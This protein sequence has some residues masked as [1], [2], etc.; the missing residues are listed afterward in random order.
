M[1]EA[2]G[3]GRRRSTIV[4]ATATGGVLAIA[5]AL[6]ATVITFATAPASLLPTVTPSPKDYV[7]PFE[8][9]LDRGPGDPFP[10]DLARFG[11]FVDASHGFL[12]VY[13][14]GRN[15]QGEPDSCRTVIMATNDG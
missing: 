3:S 12:G 14:C 13:R 15:P 1:T 2:T 9:L 7:A 5:A 4:G 11:R 8:R 10:N 6:V